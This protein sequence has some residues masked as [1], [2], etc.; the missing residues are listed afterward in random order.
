RS[1]WP[2]SSG[3]SRARR[4]WSGYAAALGRLAPVFEEAGRRWFELAPVVGGF[5]RFAVTPAA[6]RL[7]LP[8]VRWLSK[9]SETVK[10]TKS[11]PALDDAL[12]NLL[13]EAWDR[14][15][16]ELAQD[17]GLMAAFQGT[18]TRLAAAGTHAALA[19]RDR[20]VGAL[21]G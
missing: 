5:A 13:R 10:L 11:E 15:R 4:G 1:G 8:A 12:I 14:H 16:A 21:G 7:L 20:V 9:A 17:A 6:A 2:S 19:L 18:L 3:K